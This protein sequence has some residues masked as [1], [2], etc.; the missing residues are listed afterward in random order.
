MT[1][2]T[3]KY[4]ATKMFNPNKNCPF[5]TFYIIIQNTIHHSEHTLTM[6]GKFIHLTTQLNL[7]FRLATLNRQLLTEI[8][9]KLCRFFRFKWINSP[10]RVRWLIRRLQKTNLS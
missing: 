4:D 6:H 5:T 8:Y 1:K 7:L 3:S 10:L 9:L 2:A